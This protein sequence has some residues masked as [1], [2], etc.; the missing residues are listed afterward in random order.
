MSNGTH[1]RG[2]NPGRAGG[3]GQRHGGGSGGPYVPE[4]DLSGVS[5]K[6]KIDPELFNGVAR[7][8]AQTVA[9]P[10]RYQKNKPS[11]L[12]RFYDE[13]VMWSNKVEQAPGRFDDYLPFIRMLNAKAA[14]A[15][16]R[17]LVDANFVKLLSHCL[18]QVD[19]PETLHYAKVFFEAFLGFYKEVR[20][21]DS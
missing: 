8:A 7:R 19:R 10:D 15:D 5:F 16:G 1:K 9:G 18:G 11:Q 2:Y 17:D 3:G 4:I 21:K 12:R 6:D 14:Y 13:L 20:P